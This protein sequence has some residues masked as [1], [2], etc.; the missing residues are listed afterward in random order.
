MSSVSSDRCC[1]DN[2]GGG[3]LSAMPVGILSAGMPPDTGPCRGG[4]CGCVTVISLVGLMNLRAVT[5]VVPAVVIEEGV[6]PA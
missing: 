1:N 4:D 3:D 5:G 6:E 2:G